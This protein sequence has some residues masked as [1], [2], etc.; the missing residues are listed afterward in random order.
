MTSSDFQEDLL[1]V[2][3]E[4]DQPAGENVERMPGQLVPVA[5]KPFDDAAEEESI[6]S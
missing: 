6:D 5:F 1:S 4:E 2:E 3:E